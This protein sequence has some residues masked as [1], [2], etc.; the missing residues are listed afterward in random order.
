MLKTNWKFKLENGNEY[1]IM[2]QFLSKDH[3]LKV[4][5]Q[6]FYSSKINK[7]FI[8]FLNTIVFEKQYRFSNRDFFKRYYLGPTN[9]DLL[10]TDNLLNENEV[11]ITNY[12]QESIIIT[13]K[14]FY[15][16]T[17]ILAH[18]ALEAVTWFDLIEKGIVDKQWV[19]EVKQWILNNE[20]NILK[21]QEDENV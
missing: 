5:L 20:E 14:D 21:L 11:E 7:D 3:N 10:E 9:P 19:S 17:L 2:H 18:K 4:G 8:T 1:Y 15:Y 6:T 16:S 13:K 12:L